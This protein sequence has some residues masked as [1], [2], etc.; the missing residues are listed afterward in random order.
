[1]EITQTIDK[2]EGK[3]RHMGRFAFFIESLKN[4][5]T[6]GT[7]TRSSRFL[8]QSV[9]RHADLKKAH[10]VVE[11]GAGDGVMTRHLLKAM[12][13]DSYLISFEINKV[14]CERLSKINDSRLIII[15]DSA[16][17]LAQVIE[18]RGLDKVDVVVSALPFSVFPEDLTKAIVGQCHALMRAGCRFV[19]IHYSLKT[20]EIYRNIFGNVGSAFEV[21]NIPP[22]YVLYCFKT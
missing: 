21:R 17:T 15:N 9:V 3:Y 2:P 22:A 10:V 16:E 19:Q 12:S 5:R 1:M 13:K 14:F 11:L 7:V 18:S 4:I 8:C 6:V 20:K